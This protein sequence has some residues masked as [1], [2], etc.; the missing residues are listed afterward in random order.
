MGCS[1]ASAKD[2]TQDRLFVKRRPVG[3]RVG[4]IV[5]ALRRKN[6]GASSLLADSAK[7]DGG[8]G[9]LSVITR[10][11]LSDLTPAYLVFGNID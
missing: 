4:S 7:V 9:G 1:V 6:A 11:L 10:N 2:V 5:A 3:M 8:G